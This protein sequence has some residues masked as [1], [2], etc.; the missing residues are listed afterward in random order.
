[1]DCNTNKVP[2]DTER[3]LL[4]GLVRGAKT[5]IRLKMVGQFSNSSWYAME[6]NLLEPE[7]FHQ[8]PSR[9]G[10]KATPNTHGVLATQP[11]LEF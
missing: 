9:D 11:N 8:Q 2:Q 5:Q 3:R 1:M 10:T 6:E 4:Q 7:N